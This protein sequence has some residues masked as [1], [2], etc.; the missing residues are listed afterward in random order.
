M[1][2]TNEK[3]WESM[4]TGSLTVDVD[5]MIVPNSRCTCLGFRDDDV[6]LSK[7]R[8]ARKLCELNGSS[9]DLEDLLVEM[10]FTA[11]HPHTE[12]WQ[13]RP[14]R[15]FIGGKD[16]WV[17]VP[18]HYPAKLFRGVTEGNIAVLTVPCWL[19]D[20]VS[21]EVHIENII[22]SIRANQRHY[23]W[24]NFGDVDATSPRWTWL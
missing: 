8:I 22:F 9:F 4:S 17:H 19:E 5:G 11:D 2:M 12:D 15:L 6:A 24:R 20:C 7:A 13:S 10:V 21:R 18:S 3:T 16:Y 23:K 1:V 14:P